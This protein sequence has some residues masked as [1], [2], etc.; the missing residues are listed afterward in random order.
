MDLLVK[1]AISIALDRSAREKEMVAVALAA[2][3]PEMLDEWTMAKGEQGSWVKAGA[4]VGIRVMVAG[5]ARSLKKFGHDTLNSNRSSCDLTTLRSTALHCTARHYA[6]TLRHG[7]P[8]VRN[9]TVQ[10]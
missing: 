5:N 1:K 7:K 3:S 6:L 2:L 9:G 10:D 4:R 8:C